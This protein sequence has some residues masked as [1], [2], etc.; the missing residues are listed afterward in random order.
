MTIT[1]QKLPYRY[2]EQT[3]NYKQGKGRQEGHHKGRKNI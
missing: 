2:R 1:K 3:N